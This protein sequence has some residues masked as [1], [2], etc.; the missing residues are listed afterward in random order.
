MTDSPIKVGLLFSETGVTS[1][2]ERPQRNATLLAIDEINAA[3]GVDG[4]PV[5]ALAMDPAS[6]PDVYRRQAEEMTAELGISVI[7]GCYMSSTRKAVLPVVE[8]HRALLFYPTL[9]EGFE[10]SN[11]VIYT[12]AA[13][14]Q[15]SVQLFHYLL[16]TF[17]DRFFLVGSDYIYPYESN[18]IMR[19]LLGQV[20]GS[21]VRERYL[22]LT[23]VE[24]DYRPIVAEIAELAPDVVFSTVVGRSTAAF[25][26]AYRAAGLDPARMPI[27]SLTTTEAEVRAM[28]AEAAEG[29]ITSAP[30]FATIERPQNRRFVESYGARYGDEAPVNHCAEAAYFQVHLFAQ[31]L[32]DAGTCG[33][34]ALE[35][36]LRGQSFDAP[37]GL[38]TIDPEN[39]HTHL[40]P[41]LGRVDAAGRFEILAESKSAVR[42]DPYLVTPRLDQL[43][44]GLRQR[45]A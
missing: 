23:A 1:V 18:R 33:F 40:W 10:Y 27:A 20:G 16:E 34:E 14:N 21:A 39:H 37:Q 22:P 8:R 31:A 36:A 32:R 35:A 13:P 42:P 4:R 5:E 9:Y 44:A 38:V 7:F 25:Y 12:G 6:E 3:G 24:E 11:H 43:A 26:R 30:Y 45:S 28:G 17:G 41:R 2:I 19:D 29:H 15:N